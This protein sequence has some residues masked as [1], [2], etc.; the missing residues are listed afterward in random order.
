MAWRLIQM[1][2]IQETMASDA[3]GWVAPRDQLDDDDDAH[4][5]CDDVL[6]NILRATI[7]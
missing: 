4:Q 5:N 7:N 1:L 2:E 3:S 6:M